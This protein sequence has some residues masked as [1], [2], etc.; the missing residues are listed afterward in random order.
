MSESLKEM[1][2]H[3]IAKGHSLKQDAARELAAFEGAAGRIAFLKE[4]IANIDT[5]LISLA[6]NVKDAGL[7]FLN[8]TTATHMPLE[9]KKLLAANEPPQA[10]P[11]VVEAEAEVAGAGEQAAIALAVAARNAGPS[12]Y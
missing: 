6:R 5:Q 7:Y 2:T 8:W 9:A 10:P 3:M 4:H 1:Y 12:T 11:D